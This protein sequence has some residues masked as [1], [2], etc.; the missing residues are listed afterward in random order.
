[1]LIFNYYGQKNFIYNEQKKTR[2]NGHVASK[3]HLECCRRGCKFYVY[4][5][6]NFVHEKIKNILTSG[7]A[8]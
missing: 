7:N 4:L 3:F 6:I 1:M 2:K 5:E 8:C